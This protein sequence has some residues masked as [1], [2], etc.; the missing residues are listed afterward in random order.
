MALKTSP[1]PNRMY[2]GRSQK[3]LMGTISLAPWIPFSFMMCI[4]L[5]STKYATM[6]TSIWNM[7]PIPSLCSKV[8]P[9]GFPVFRRMNGTKHRSY[10]GTDRSIES[11][12]KLPSDAAGIWKLSPRCRSNVVPCLTNRV[13]TWAQMVL[14]IRVA[15]HTTIIPNTSLVSSTCVTVYGAEFPTLPSLMAALSRNLEKKME[16]SSCCYQLQGY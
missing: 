12:T 10:I 6:V 1:T 2:W 7:N 8:I 11:V 3:M 16:G 14:G 9:L 13:F 15:S 5:N 4:L